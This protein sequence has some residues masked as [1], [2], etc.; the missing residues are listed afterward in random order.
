[1]RRT[2]ALL[3]A[4]GLLLTTQVADASSIR[5]ISLWEHVY[6]SAVIV[7]ADVESV[8]LLRPPPVNN[9]DGTITVTTARTQVKFSLRVREV[10][11][12]RA[13]ETLWI[14]LPL[15][16]VGSQFARRLLRRIVRD[17]ASPVP[18][19]GPIEA[20]ETV[21]AFF[22]RSDL[23]EDSRRAGK[24]LFV[25]LLPQPG[26]TEG[27]REVVAAA[28]DVQGKRPYDTAGALSP[29]ESF[30]PLYHRWRVLAL[31]RRVTRQQLLDDGET[32]TPDALRRS[33]RSAVSTR[34]D[35]TVLAEGFVR[36]PS[37]GFG[38]A[39]ILFLLRGYESPALDEMAVGCVESMLANTDPLP[40]DAGM[41]AA[42]T[43]E[44]HGAAE[45]LW[46]ELAA[47]PS[48]IEADELRLLWERA[49]RAARVPPVSSQVSAKLAEIH[50]QIPE[51]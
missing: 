20:P 24:A 36:E 12:G 51:R 5:T 9:P 38:L 42:L 29:E 34:G 22:D 26:D 46:T 50:D 39:Q 3:G 23:S 32:V 49:A 21:V 8:E 7:L 18:S 6:G 35:Q 44:R 1:M 11:K 47:A 48:D 10:W 2:S 40:G 28:V 43:L 17:L 45:K 41:A 16:R 27:W 30:G 37:L 13:S 4:C 31:A 14:E 33:S 15:H 19:P 25:R